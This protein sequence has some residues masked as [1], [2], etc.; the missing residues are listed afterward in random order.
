MLDSLKGSFWSMG[1]FGSQAQAND[2]AQQPVPETSEVRNRLSDLMDQLD[3]GFAKSSSIEAV[4]AAQYAATRQ[5]READPRAP[6]AE[7]PAAAPEPQPPVPPE[8]QPP[9]PPEQPLLHVVED[10]VIREDVVE[11]AMSDVMSDALRFA[12]DQRKAAEALLLEACVLEERLKH[13]AQVAGVMHEA[14]VANGQAA[15]AAAE[16]EQAARMAAQKR[17]AHAVAQAEHKELHV[18][19]MG[20]RAEAAAADAKIEEIARALQDAKNYAAQIRTAISE[21]EVRAMEC[22]DKETAA[23]IEETQ[24]IE[25]LQACRANQLAAEARAAAARERAETLKNSQSN[26]SGPAGLEAVQALAARIAER[27]RLVKHPD[28]SERETAAA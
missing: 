6:V 20:K 13:E 24:A 16:A 1:R 17:D 2:D 4:K 18:L 23:R 19:L 11:D 10:P 3:A 7:V 22:A 9:V 26:Q 28:P 27:A 12:A 5:G 25:R 21:Q 8:P 15:H 14:D